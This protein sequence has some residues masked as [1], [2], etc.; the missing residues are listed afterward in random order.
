MKQLTD[1]PMEK[2]FIKAHQVEQKRNGNNLKLGF[3]HKIK[4]IR[5]DKPIAT[6]TQSFRDN[7]KS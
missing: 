7:T 6:L 1:I 2:C 5:K 3:I 4:K